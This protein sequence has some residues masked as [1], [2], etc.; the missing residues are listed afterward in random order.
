[1]KVMKL[2]ALIAAV[3]LMA[4]APALAQTTTTPAGATATTPASVAF[5]GAGLGAGL[6]MAFT[7]IGAGY[8]LGKIGSAAL[9]GM[10]RQPE[11]AR[12]HPDGH[13]YHCRHARRRDSGQRHP[14]LPD[15]HQRQVLISVY[16]I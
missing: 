5:S 14:V 12:A 11:V 15:W 2:L 4:A 9:D 8:G 1:M 7:I 10:A 6:G 16:F 3:M 13:D